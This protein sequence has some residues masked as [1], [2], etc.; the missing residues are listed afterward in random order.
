MAGIGYVNIKVYFGT[1]YDAINI[2][3][4]INQIK[5]E[6][7]KILNYEGYYVWQTTWLSAI[8]IN[9]QTDYQEIVGAQYVEMEDAGADSYG[10][11]WYNVIG[12]DNL[13]NGSAM[14]YLSYNP[15]LTL[16]F[17]WM[18]GQNWKCSGKFERWT[19]NNDANFRY[20]ATPEPVDLAAPMSYSYIRLNPVGLEVYPIAGFPYDMTNAPQVLTY[21]DTNIYYPKLTAITEPTNFKINTPLGER[22]STDGMKYCAWK[23]NSSQFKN[24]NLAT[25]LGMEII[26]QGYKLPNT[27]LIPE[28]AVLTTTAQ[29]S[30]LTGNFEDYN[31]GFSL[32]DG[33]W[34]NAK[35]GY[36]NIFLTLYNE[37][38]GDA[39]TV[40][41][42]DLNNTAITI[43]VNPYING[44][45]WARFDTYLK[46]DSGI[47]GLVKSPPW[48][49]LTIASSSPQNATANLLSTYA[50]QNLL[51]IQ[52]FNNIRG[53]YTSYR[54]SLEGADVSHTVTERNSAMQAISGAFQMVG[55]LFDNLY[56]AYQKNTEANFNMGATT[57]N[58]ASLVGGAIVSTLNNND[59]T[60][61]AERNAERAYR[62]AVQAENN[63]F[64]VQSAILEYQGTLG[65]ILPPIVK[66]AE[67]GAYTANTFTFCVRKATP[68]NSD[69]ARIDKFFT[70]YGY[71][72]NGES[73]T[74]FSQLN[75]RSRFT[76]AKVT[77]FKFVPGGPGT[78][79]LDHMTQEYFTNMMSRGVRIWKTTPD[80]DYTKSNPITGG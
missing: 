76:F 28:I 5:Q 80:F 19:V 61:Q 18:Y 10:N 69:R 63:I 20:V 17:S 12:Y 42:Y 15:Y 26:C 70:Q 56:S 55:G 31:T 29:I 48:E 24:F 65:Q 25:E 53:S 54:E 51:S 75:C 30:Q 41:S 1:L 33:G 44:G 77:D 9:L 57:A 67:S 22:V 68:S 74:S 11:H 60:S 40:A 37:D 59:T 46:D 52:H 21:E 45:F 7:T 6:A 49:Q 78:R 27:P 73:L 32:S 36:S 39:V 43:G 13:N 47:T 71:N 50:S 14:L 16:T 66:A 58:A 72:V 38:S 3:W 2:P 23:P 35:T 62:E 64:K 79:T 8:T 34:N 4:S